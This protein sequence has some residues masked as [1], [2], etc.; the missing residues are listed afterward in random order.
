MRRIDIV[1]KKLEE[2]YQEEGLTTIEIANSLGLSRANVSSDLNRLCEEGKAVKKKGKPALFTPVNTNN[3]NLRQEMKKEIKEETDKINILDIFVNNNKSLYSAVEQAKAAILY[4]PNGMNMLILGETGVG[5]SMFVS[6]IHKYAVVMN[7]FEDKSPFIIFNCADYANNPQ[8]LLGQLFG[9]KKGA[10]TGAD[11]DRIGLIEKADKGILFLDEVHRLPSEGQEMLFTF[12]DN[13]TFRRLGETEK[14]RKSDVLIICA[15]T[16]DPKESLLQT[17]TR[18]IPMAITIP[19]LRERTMEERFQLISTFMKD[20]SS[21]LNKEIKVSINSIKALLCYDCAS[22]IGQL[23]VDIQL[24]CAKIYAKYISEN[25]NTIEI[26]SLDL[27][28]HIRQGLYNAV[29]HRKLWNKLIDINKKSCI[30][31]SMSNDVIFE[32]YKEKINIYEMVELRYRELK[33]RGIEEEKLQESMKI[34]IENYFKKYIHKLDREINSDFNLSKLENIISSEILRVVL[35]I[36]KHSEE[37]LGRT[38]SQKVCY[39]M[40]VHINSAIERIRSNKKVINPQLNKIRIEYEVEFNVSLDCLRII[41]RLLDIS[42]PIDEAGF[43]T[44]FLVYDNK[45]IKDI[46]EEVKVIVIAH[47]ESTATSMAEAANK[48]LGNEYTVGINAPLDE[49]P[50]Y[51]LHNLKKYIKDNNITSNILLL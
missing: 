15:T 25:K 32:E 35:E 3:N 11:T 39:G 19:P 36:F 13:K 27:P 22:N 12:M 7:R 47:G 40:A 1:L 16:E 44:M 2:L 50:E 20:E 49:K 6:L 43:L 8:L 31:N 24:I 45:K 34:D 9:C 14:E 42:M 29:E 46:K 26:N 48:L 30:F 10:Y 51:I 28:V 17:F 23:K 4:P 5:K 37:K 38:L 18:R 21:R 41:E 33:S